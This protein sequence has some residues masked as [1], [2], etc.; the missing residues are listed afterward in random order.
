VIFIDAEDAV[1]VSRNWENAAA[2]AG[3]REGSPVTL[4]RPASR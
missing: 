1:F 3:V 4:R 2:S